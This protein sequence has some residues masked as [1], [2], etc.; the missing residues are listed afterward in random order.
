MFCVLRFDRRACQDGSVV[1]LVWWRLINPVS[2]VGYFLASTVDCCVWAVVGLFVVWMVCR[3]IT[4]SINIVAAGD[5]CVVSAERTQG[6]AYANTV[7]GDHL[8]DRRD[9]KHR[10]GQNKEQKR[11]GDLQGRPSEEH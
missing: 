5:T 10:H 11:W 1:L 9:K 6:R 4:S 7:Q 2:C 3:P 8:S